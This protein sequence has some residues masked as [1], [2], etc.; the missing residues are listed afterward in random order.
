MFD[1]F[2]C[3]FNDFDFMFVFLLLFINGVGVVGLMDLILIW[4]RII[5][6][7]FLFLFGIEIVLVDLIFFLLE[8]LRIW[9]FMVLVGIEGVNFFIVIF[10]IIGFDSKGFFIILK[11]RVFF[12]LG[13]ILVFLIVFDGFV[14]IEEVICLNGIVFILEWGCMLLMSGLFIILVGCCIFG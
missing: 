5:G 12:L 1:V 8:V 4:L 10:G 2:V 11:L 14:W 7:K 3:F 13:W 9:I 6:W